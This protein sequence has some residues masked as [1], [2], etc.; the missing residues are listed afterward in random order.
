MITR[1]TFRRRAGLVVAGA[2]IAGS[3]AACTTQG[4]GSNSA[5]PLDCANAVPTEADADTQVTLDFWMLPLL[6]GPYGERDGGA[7]DWGNRIIEEFEAKYPNVT[8]KQEML[9]Y[10]GYDQKIKTA[11]ASGTMPDVVLAGGMFGG[12]QKYA[13][14]GALDPIN[15]FVTDEDRADFT[16][17]ALDLMSYEGEEYF[18][19]L[20]TLVSGV[21][22]N[23]DMAE[24]A[25]ATDILPLGDDQVE[26]TFDEFEEFAA[27]INAVAP[28]QYAYPVWGKDA[29]FYDALWVVNAGGTFVDDSL[30]SFVGDQNP[31]TA[32][33][34]DYLA[35]L[36]EQG[37][38]P[39][40]AAGLSFGDTYNLFLQQKIAMFP[41]FGLSEIQQGIAD[42]GNPFDIGVVAPPHADGVDTSAWTNSAGFMIFKQTDNYERFLAN[43]FARMLTSTEENMVVAS[44]LQVFPAR[45]SANSAIEDNES[46][47]PFLK[48]LPFANPQF[49]REY[50]LINAT[51]WE[52]AI[53]GV[54]TGTTTGQ[55]AVESLK[56]PMTDALNAR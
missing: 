3:L 17:A 46:I 48:L 49:T 53:Q 54:L 50:G 14:L 45:T 15:C 11:I 44:A 18:W 33:G 56:Q 40:G 28:D 55:Q 31:A 2:I 42:S 37:F 6:E 7:E 38:A 34:F 27:K 8:V 1:S 47:E 10:D 13:A 32:E 23:L 39:P 19:P 43:E 21:V 30:T 22:V 26:W 5:D 20:E 24:A 51:D 52:T 4:G 29:A 35:S 25:G 12:A 41:V 36:S 9:S 16:S